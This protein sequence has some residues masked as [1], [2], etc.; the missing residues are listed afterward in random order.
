MS[1]QTIF[2]DGTIYQK[3]KIN[4]INK[5]LL[6]IGEVPLQ[7]GTLVDS[8]ELGT[9]GDTARRM[10]E[11]TM[12]EVQSI[13]WYFNLDYNFKLYKDVHDMIPVP[14]NVLRIDTQESNRYVDKNGRLYDNEKQTFIIVPTYIEADIVWLVDFPTLP[15]EAYEY[16]AARAARKFQEVVIGAPDLTNTTSRVEQ[17]TY[18]RMQRRQL[19][20]RAYNIQ[21]NKVSTRVHSGYLKNSLYGNKGRL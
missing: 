1:S 11:E 6:A 21:N 7:E 18:V 2:A 10:V 4:M 8:L 13:G 19:Q 5:C 3:T 12:V 9:D 17:E 15:P 14:P 16:I 20:T